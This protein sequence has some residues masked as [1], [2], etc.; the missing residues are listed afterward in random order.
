MPSFNTNNFLPLLSGNFLF[1]DIVCVTK[2]NTYLLI[3]WRVFDTHTHTIYIYIYI[4]TH[5][6][7]FSQF[8]ATV[9]FRTSHVARY[10]LGRVAILINITRKSIER[11]FRK[12]S[13]HSHHSDHNNELGCRNDH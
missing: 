13:Y 5:T 10:V 3:K 12:L 4:Y 9:R 8:K 2:L 6:L 11:L 1:V 7:N